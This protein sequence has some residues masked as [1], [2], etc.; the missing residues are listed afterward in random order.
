MWF[1]GVEQGVTWLNGLR[2]EKNTWCAH[3]THDYLL[4][5]QNV[6]AKMT[7]PLAKLPKIA[8]N[9]GVLF[10]TLGWYCFSVALSLGYEIYILATKCQNIF[11]LSTG[12]ITCTLFHQ[13]VL[14]S[15]IR[16]PGKVCGERFYRFY[17]TNCDNTKQREFQIL[18]CFP[19]SISHP[20]TS[21]SYTRHLK[22]TWKL[23]RVKPTKLI[24]LPR[25]CSW[26]NLL[27]LHQ[28]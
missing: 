7:N 28:A 9:V 6:Y 25:S 23:I 22:I 17:Y 12:R 5:R 4:V 24:S 15:K 21:I 16:K 26:G 27:G 3:T 13:Q 1:N 8:L 11:L 20:P 14:I 10:N 18:T 19:Q 2:N